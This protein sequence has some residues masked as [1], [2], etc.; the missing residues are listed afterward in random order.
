MP[1]K[2]LVEEFAPQKLRL[3]VDDYH[4]MGAAGVFE[5]KSRVELIQGEIYTM[6]PLSPGHNAHVDKISR[7][8]HSVL[9]DQVLVRTQ[10]SVQIDEYTEPEP[11]IVLLHPNADFY[12]SRQAT[13]ADIHLLIE[14]SVHTLKTDRSIKKNQYAQALVPEYWIVIPQ[15]HL[16]E[17]YKKPDSGIYQEKNTYRMGDEWLFEPF[18]LWVKAHDLLI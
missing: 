12:S 9:Y 15:R 14:V 3:T 6:S 16:I 17:V 1:V 5:N 10:G 4:R 2:Q 8:F 13:A 18:Q 11:D 7:F